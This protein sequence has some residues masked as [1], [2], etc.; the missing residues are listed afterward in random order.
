M[1]R[2]TAATI[3][4]RFVTEHNQEDYKRSLDELTA[5]GCLFHESLPGV[6]PAMERTHYEGFVGAFRASMPDIRNQVDEVLVDGDLAA[7]RWTGH[8]THTGEALMGLPARG[9]KVVAHGVYVMRFAG[10]RIAEVWSAWDGLAVMEQ[11]K[12]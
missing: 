11:L 12:S 6:P 2:E 1:N 7:V 8:G 9:K 5:P 10:E 4:K 3:A